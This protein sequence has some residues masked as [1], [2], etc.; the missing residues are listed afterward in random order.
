MYDIGRNLKCFIASKVLPPDI[1]SHTVCSANTPVTLSAFPGVA[2]GILCLSVILAWATVD[3][4]SKHSISPVNALILI[5]R[6][7]MLM[8][9]FSIT[10]VLY[11]T[12]SS[13]IALAGVVRNI[14]TCVFAILGH[15]WT[16]YYSATHG[17]SALTSIT[18]ETTRIIFKTCWDIW[19]GTWLLFRCVHDGIL[20][21]LADA[22]SKLVVKPNSQSWRSAVEK[23]RDGSQ[24]YGTSTIVVCFAV[25][26]THR[27]GPHPSVPRTPS[28]G[29][30]PVFDFAP[31][32]LLSA[33][34][35]A[36][37]SVPR[38]ISTTSI[39]MSYQH[40][41]VCHHYYEVLRINRPSANTTLDLSL[42][43]SVNPART[44]FALNGG[45][46]PFV[47]STT[48]RR[49]TL[50][51]SAPVFIPD[52]H[53]T[54]NPFA[55]D[56]VPASYYD[57]LPPGFTVQFDLMSHWAQIYAELYAQAV[58]EVQVTQGAFLERPR[59]RK[60]VSGKERRLRRKAQLAR[61]AMKE[62]EAMADEF[63]ASGEGAMEVSLLRDLG[64][65]AS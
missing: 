7:S 41:F 6:F 36:Y 23:G 9:N 57:V 47:P 8:L 39:R 34:V 62:R 13:V 49:H 61:K 33:F 12:V 17:V 51:A 22:L 21:M 14:C 48:R 25:V 37:Y 53:P 63:I 52:A 55:E 10:V 29:S 65:V 43:I 31:E 2:I 18:W 1:L 38:L 4:S 16:Y 54:L 50:N 64:A 15:L 24:V 3:T 11:L 40:I 58:W 26:L 35:Y 60:S 59:K 32:Q 45:A 56:F 30:K 42:S 27:Q 5:L 46:A 19:D 28:S 44:P 20:E